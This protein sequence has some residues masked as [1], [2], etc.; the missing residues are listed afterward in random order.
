M[1]DIKFALGTSTDYILIGL[2][3]VSKI[4]SNP[5][6]IVEVGSERIAKML[7]E[8]AQVVEKYD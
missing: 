6:Y 8:I 3:S 1:L 2:D 5:G 7:N 4:D